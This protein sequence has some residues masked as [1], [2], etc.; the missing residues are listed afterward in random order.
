MDFIMDLPSSHGFDTLLVVVDWLSKQSHFIPM[1]Q[2]LDTPRLAQLY[3]SSIFK[4][5]G[6]PSS[7]VSDR[8]PL[9]TSL[10]WNSLTS[11]LSIQLKLSTA[12]HPQTD[13]QT[14]QVNQCMEQYLQNYCSYQQDDW[15]NWLG[16]AEFQYNNLIHDSTHV[17]PFFTNYGFN[18]SFT[19]P[20]LHQSLTPASG[21][22][23]SHLS[24]ICSKLKAELKLAQETAM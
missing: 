3:I 15:V 16:L 4:L 1:V 8:D 11:Q 22:L 5:H 24:T 2:S 20:H 7:I 12:Y 6:L 10:F 19:I 9:F 21:D 17:L 14:E 13:G 18:P 23:L